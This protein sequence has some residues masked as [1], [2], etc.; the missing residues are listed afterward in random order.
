VPRRLVDAGPLYADVDGDDAHHDASLEL[1]ETQ[2]GP[3]IVPILVVTEVTRLLATRLGVEPEVR[4]LGDLS[5]GVFSIS[6]RARDRYDGDA[7]EYGAQKPCKRSQSA[8]SNS[9]GQAGQ[10]G[11]VVRIRRGRHRT[12]KPCDQPGADA[13]NG[14]R[15]ADSYSGSGAMSTPFGQ[16]IVADSGSIA[17]RARSRG[18][19]VVRAP[20]ANAGTFREAPPGGASRF[21]LPVTMETAGIEPASA[22]A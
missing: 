12:T 1:V 5:S 19:E 13:G 8:S 3:L 16:A 15:I 17:T 21:A 22:I 9:S 7:C 11:R 18:R 14:L 6:H 2:P 4:F 10:I 20:G